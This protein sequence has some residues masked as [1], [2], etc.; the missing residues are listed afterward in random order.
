MDPTLIQIN[1]IH[2]HTVDFEIRFS[3]ILILL[4]PYPNEIFPSGIAYVVY[5]KMTNPEFKPLLFICY[6]LQSPEVE[7]P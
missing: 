1:A 4:P 7:F 3:N 6:G 5:I 2:I